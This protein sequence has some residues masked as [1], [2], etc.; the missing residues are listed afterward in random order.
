MNHTPTQNDAHGNWS[1][2]P[3]PKSTEVKAWE[4]LLEIAPE[5][6][7]LLPRSVNEPR[8]PLTPG[9]HFFLQM[10]ACLKNP[11]YRAIIQAIVF[12]MID[13]RVKELIVAYITEDT[14][15]EDS[16]SSTNSRE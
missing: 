16:Q 9:K 7:H 1:N 14:P 12:D 2:P 4:L 5:I 10:V 3:T 6:K 11:V 8:P 15:W 13:D